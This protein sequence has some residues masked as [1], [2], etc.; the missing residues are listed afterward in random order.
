VQRSSRGLGLAF[1]LAAAVFAVDQ[2]SKAFVRGAAARLPW[3]FAG[4]LTVDL[5]YNSG[6]SFSRFAG[7]GTIVVVLVGFMVVAVTAAL[8]VAP[9]RYRAAL[10]IILGGAASNLVDRFRFGGAVVDFLG[11]YGWPAFNLADAFIV[12]GTILLALQ[13]L[14]ASRS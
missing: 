5:N 13:V 11:V 9:Q 3:R 12:A 6:I 2:L 4:G 8:F 10:G 1:A 14:R 7:A